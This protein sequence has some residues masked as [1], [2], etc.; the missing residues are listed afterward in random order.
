MRNRLA[1]RGRHGHG[2]IHLMRGVQ[3]QIEVL[4]KEFG[5]ERR[6]PIEIH[7]RRRLVLREDRAHDPF[8]RARFRRR[9]TR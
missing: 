1:R 6:R 5:R 8:D 7:K 2:N 4:E 9:A 3:T